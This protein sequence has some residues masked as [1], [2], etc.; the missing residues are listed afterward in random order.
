MLVMPLVSMPIPILVEL[1][2][3]VFAFRVQFAATVIRLAA[4]LTVSANRL[5]K[6]RLCLLDMM[7]A[8]FFGIL[9]LKAG[10]RHQE[11]ER[12]KSYHQ[13]TRFSS[14]SRVA[15]VNVHSFLLKMYAILRPSF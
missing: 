4:V 12:R 5:V 3:A 15:S 9:R 13:G 8:S 7:L 14:Q 11:R 1:A 6:S 10:Y 2:P